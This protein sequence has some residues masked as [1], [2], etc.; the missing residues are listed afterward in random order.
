MPLKKRKATTRSS[1]HDFGMI[2]QEKGE[3]YFKLNLQI[4]FI[5]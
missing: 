1:R 4:R 2:Y 3:L 5:K